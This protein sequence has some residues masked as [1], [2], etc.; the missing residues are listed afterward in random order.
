MKYK[1]TDNSMIDNILKHSQK[2]FIQYKKIPGR[3]RAIFL[4][5]IADEIE[6]VKDELISS[7]MRETNLPE[8]RLSGET[9]RTTDQI[10]MFAALLDEGSWVEAR[11]D[12]ALPERKPVPKTDLRKMVI[13]IGPVAVFG[14]ANFPIAF[15]AAGGDTISALAAGCSVI[16]KAHPAHP[17]T[18]TL[19]ANAVTRAAEKTGMPE[20]VYQHISL[21]GK[22]GI[23]AGQGL[24]THPLLKG[25][26]FTGSLAGGRALF[27]LA[28]S[29]PEPIPFFAEMSSINPV[30][31]LPETL[32]RDAQ[33]SAAKLAGSISLGAGQFCTNP[34]LIIAVEG[35]PLERFIKSLDTEIQKI[36]PQ[37]MLNQGIAENY[38]RKLSHALMQKGVK[39]EC[40][41]HSDAS[42]D[43]GKPLVASANAETF[44]SNSELAHEVFGPFSLII[45]CRD[46]EE[47]Y[48]VSE[49]FE[50]QLTI[51][52]T[53]SE[54]ELLR[55]KKL[56][57]IIAEKAGR[58]IVND[59]PTGVEVCHSM[60][61]G[62]PYPASTDS[63]FT[64]VGTDAIKRFSRPAAFQNFPDTLLPDELKESN[65]LSIWR[66]VNGEWKK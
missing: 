28:N 29:R 43:R 34:G 46:M 4:R 56:V 47:L 14:A 7:A 10:R 27:D 51:T 50:G 32:S 22:E 9:K 12:T 39:T 33:K 48:S 44:I 18:S 5:A 15:S 49:S 8:M 52:L 40:W 62:G 41:A 37:K 25:A 42:S 23:D 45:R 20:R 60:Q 54:E 17:E 16:V 19:A 26:G 65:P 31:L 13:P 38:Y 30:I 21:Q 2:A 64:S 55:N 61:H 59:V 24:I 3:I 11:I 53:G 66:L 36:L 63:R 35:E 58:L 57:D 1:N 6:A